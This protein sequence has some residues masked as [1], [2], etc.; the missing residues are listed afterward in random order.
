M[1]RDY[2]KIIDYTNFLHN[3][4]VIFTACYP[5]QQRG[6]YNILKQFEYVYLEKSV[7]YY[8]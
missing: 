5:K 8:N 3:N 4:E 2:A 6:L 7:L 1:R